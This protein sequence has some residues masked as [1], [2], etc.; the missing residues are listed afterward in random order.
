MVVSRMSLIQERKRRTSSEIML[1]GR[2]NNVRT[3]IYA[4]QEMMTLSRDSGTR[5]ADRAPVTGV[6][7]RE[8]VDQAANHES[9]IH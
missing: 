6:K 7:S 3:S 4:P 9:R 8:G 1:T 5:I 2:K